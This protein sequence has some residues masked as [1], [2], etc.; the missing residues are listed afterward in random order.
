MNVLLKVVWFKSRLKEKQIGSSKEQS[1]KNSNSK[2]LFPILTK[3]S[4]NQVLERVS[5]SFNLTNVI[6]LLFKSNSENKVFLSDYFRW[7]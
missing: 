2:T 1:L 7:S 6:Q 5:S 4:E 3:R